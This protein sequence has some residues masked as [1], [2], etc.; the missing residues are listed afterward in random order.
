VSATVEGEEETASSTDEEKKEEDVKLYVGNLSFS[1]TP[2]DINE[3]FAPF[4]T[5][6]ETQVPKDR[7]SGMPRGFAFVSM[8]T[9]E[10]ADAAIAALNES[11]FDG[12]DLK[13]S[14]SLPVGDAP[15]NRRKG[16]DFVQRS[17]LY[18]GNISFEATAEEVADLFAEYGKVHDSYLP[19]DRETGLPRGFAFVTMDEESAKAA[20]EALDGTIFLGREVIVNESVPKGQKP[21]NSRREFS[22]GGGNTRR[23]YVGNL[24]FD[25]DEET[26]LDLFTEFGDVKEVFVPTWPD[27]GRTKGFAFVTIAS[28][29]ASV[30]IEE[31]DGLEFLGR[32]I[33]VN[34]AQKRSSNR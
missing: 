6:T 30:A 2:S 14:I 33:V 31:T 32:S 23:L 29:A 16:N 24:S 13:V 17:K 20:I 27:T 12:R 18:V 34:E 10:M 8:A 19:T 9:Q 25:A 22:E 7:K 28:D 1:S 3:L 15:P 4:G 11:E 26:L 5:I 21:P